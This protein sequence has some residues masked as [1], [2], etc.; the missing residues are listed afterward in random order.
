[1]RS[2][3]ARPPPAEIAPR[4][5]PP[6]SHW[7][8]RISS[9]LTSTQVYPPVHPLALNVCWGAQVSLVCSFSMLGKAGQ[10]ENFLPRL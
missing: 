10:L 2:D 4:P 6:A 9:S 7:A 8:P 1:M 3:Q 5:P